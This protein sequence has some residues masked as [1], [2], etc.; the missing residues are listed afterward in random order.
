LIRE[1]LRH[2]GIGR[3][4]PAPAR[5]PPRAGAI[6]YSVADPA[7]ADAGLG[8]RATVDLDEGLQRLLAEQYGLSRPCAV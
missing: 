1:M 3:E 8:F 5:A 2:A 4:L 7:K 6:R